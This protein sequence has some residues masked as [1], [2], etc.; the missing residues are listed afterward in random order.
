[1]NLNV[2]VSD[3]DGVLTFYEAPEPLGWS[4]F[5]DNKA[6]VLRGRGLCVEERSVPV[7]TLAELHRLHADRPVDFLK[8]DV[9]GYEANVLEGR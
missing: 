5:S 1:M 6:G 3:R 9:E 7:L 4:T 2:G 8:V